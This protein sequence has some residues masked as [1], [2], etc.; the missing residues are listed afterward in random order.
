MK[1]HPR[2]DGNHNQIVRALR[3]C[4]CTVQ[5]LASI[6]G[7]CPDLLVG[8]KDLIP[9]LL[10]VKSENGT[11]TPLERQWHN[12]WKG[13]VFTVRTIDEALVICG[14]TER[15]GKTW[16]TTRLDRKYGRTRSNK[17]S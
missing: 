7:G 13:P 15:K 2:L 1:R 11:L 3:S 5:S 14:I 12:R 4:G 9:R 8:C 10:E 17:S 6:G 16:P